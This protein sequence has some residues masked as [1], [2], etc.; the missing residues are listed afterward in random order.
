M[1]QCDDNFAV[2]VNGVKKQ[3]VILYCLDGVE[4]MTK[5]GWVPPAFRCEGEFSS[6]VLKKIDSYIQTQYE[7]T[8]AQW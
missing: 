3:R 2:T 8:V 4:W 7:S 1:L 5:E 6:D